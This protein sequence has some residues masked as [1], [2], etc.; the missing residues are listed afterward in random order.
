MRVALAP[1]G[2]IKT[3]GEHTRDYPSMEL[4]LEVHTKTIA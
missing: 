1:S 2:V 3:G 4:L